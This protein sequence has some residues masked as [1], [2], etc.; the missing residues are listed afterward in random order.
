[1]SQGTGRGK[2]QDS[3]SK[4]PPETQ[5]APPT[6]PLQAALQGISLLI[7][8]G[9]SPTEL[10]LCIELLKAEVHPKA[11]VDVVWPFLEARKKPDRYDF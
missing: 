11:L 10:D 3:K 7:N 5:T 2:N 6:S 8:T 9:L 4:A 1:M